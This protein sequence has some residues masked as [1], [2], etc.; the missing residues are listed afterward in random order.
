MATEIAKVEDELVGLCSLAV[1]ADQIFANVLLASGGRLYAVIPCRGYAGTFDDE[2]A[3]QEFERLLSA[4][5]EVIELPFSEPSEEAF[6]A[7]GRA[8]A[9]QCDLLLAVWDGQP[10]GGLGGT[11]DVVSHA[12]DRSKKVKI[13][14]PEGSSRS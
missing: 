12:T 6:M 3:R 7:A 2:A 5:H 11:G 13:L 4:A 8:V 9:D 1:G 14:W 10:A